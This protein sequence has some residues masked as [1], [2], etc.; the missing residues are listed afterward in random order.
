MKSAAAPLV[1]RMIPFTSTDC[2][3]SQ[4]ASA[5]QQPM[6]CDNAIRLN[7]LFCVCKLLVYDEISKQFANKYVLK[8][9]LY[10]YI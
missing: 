3:A 1:A 4:P 6:A 10:W 5:A 8:I 7:G 9:T 2:V